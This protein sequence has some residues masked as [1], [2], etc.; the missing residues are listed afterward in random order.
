M[1]PASSAAQKEP[2]RMP[3]A[4]ARAMPQ[5]TAPC[6]WWAR[7]LDREVNMMVA[8]AVP[9]AVCRMCAGGNPCALNTNTS[10]GTMTA[11]PPMPSRPARN[12]TA[13]PIAT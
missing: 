7:M 13:A 10:M 2:V 6:A 11:P 12:P 8:I 4:M 9:S 5:S 3:G 1:N